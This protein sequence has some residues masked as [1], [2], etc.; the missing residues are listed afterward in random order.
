[1]TGRDRA[2]SIRLG[3]PSVSSVPCPRR[4][5]SSQGPDLPL[6]R[7][8]AP[9][10][11]HCSS[12]FIPHSISASPDSYCDPIHIYF[13]ISNASLHW[14]PANPPLLRLFWALLAICPNPA[15]PLTPPSPSH[16]LPRLSDDNAP[17]QTAP[18]TPPA[19]ALPRPLV[20]LPQ[21][22]PPNLTGEVPP[23]Y[24][25]PRHQLSS[26]VMSSS[27]PSS[28]RPAPCPLP[29]SASVL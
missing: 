10:S 19:T 5:L 21:P 4:P 1:M 29:G 17:P 2:R 15:Q 8:P 11:H 12:Q 22:A 3:S 14:T 25:H 24:C 16:A 26:Y 7:S 20:S 9:F 6:P 23:L 18:P 28:Y 13:F 27:S